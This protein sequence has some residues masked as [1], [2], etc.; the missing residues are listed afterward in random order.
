MTSSDPPHVREGEVFTSPQIP[1]PAKALRDSS[2][3]GTHLH[4]QAVGTETNQF[5]GAPFD[6]Q[7]HTRPTSFIYYRWPPIPACHHG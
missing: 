7:E 6:P 1:E 2:F 4:I 5:Y 3:D